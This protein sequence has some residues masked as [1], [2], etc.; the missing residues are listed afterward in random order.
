MKG[1]N[2]KILVAFLGL[3]LG[4]IIVASS[5]V[6]ITRASTIYETFY[7]Q[8]EIL[9]VGALSG[10]EMRTDDPDG[11][12]TEGAMPLYF[13][14]I[15]DFGSDWTAQV[16]SPWIV[17]FWTGATVSSDILVG[18]SIVAWDGSAI[19][20]IDEVTSLISS[21]TANTRYAPTFDVSGWD[22]ESAPAGEVSV[23]H[24]RIRISFTKSGG[25]RTSKIAWNESIAGT[26]HSNVTNCYVVPERL[27]PLLLVA[28]SI[29]LIAK[30]IVQSRDRRGRR[31]VAH[32]GER[33]GK[34]RF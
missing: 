12:K 28:P 16:S 25:G 23:Y 14:T 11:A 33:R 29:P 6:P 5:N 3:F 20:G 18:V 32:E 17:E 8:N 10:Y 31:S 13:W 21:P 7:F 1:F 26:C 4:S 27:L 19:T 34:R 9:T 2:V 22:A 30:K 15:T 24:R